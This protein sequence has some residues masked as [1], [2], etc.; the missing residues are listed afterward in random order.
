MT[1]KEQK[2][3]NLILDFN[4]KVM[5]ELRLDLTPEDDLLC[6]DY[7]E[8]IIQIKGKFIKYIEDENDTLKSNE[9]WMN[10]LKN[11]Q[12][13]E[14]VCY[15]FFNR[16]C[17][18]RGYEMQS[19]SHTITPRETRG[20]FNLVYSNNGIIETISSDPLMNESNQIFNLVC[21]INGTDHMYKFDMFEVELPQRK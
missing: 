20:Q 6:D 15:P 10:F 18:E 12:L 1:K 2:E 9:I 4:D 13:L 14:M 17:M 7:N 8:I 11:P 21:K 3:W 5:R 19:L 16:Y